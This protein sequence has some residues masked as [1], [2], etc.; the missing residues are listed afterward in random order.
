RVMLGRISDGRAPLDTVHRFANVP[1][2]LPNG[3]H[4]N[5][6][7]LFA[8]TLIGLARAAEM[9]P[10]SGVGIDA[11]GVDYALLDP[12]RR[13][14]GL[15]FHYRDSRTNTIVPRA[16]ERVSRE[17]LYSVTGIQ[18][19]PINTV[20]QLLADERSSSLMLAATDRIAL[21]AD[22]FVYWLPG[23]VA[24]EVTA[25][26]TTGLLDARTGTWA[27]GIVRRLGLPERPFSRDP[28]EPGTTLGTVLAEHQAAAAS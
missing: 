25:A 8:Q 28:I 26:S 22:L 27:R 2:R 10:L 23:V 1:I 17:E 9:A 19:M 7:E 15:P 14:L 11:W 12:H 5:L 18:T 20:F 21:I 16:H 4:W 6:P 3:L 13:M 24:N